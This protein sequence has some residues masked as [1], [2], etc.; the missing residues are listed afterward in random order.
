MAHERR[1]RPRCRRKKAEPAFRFYALWDKVYRRDVLQEAYRRCRANAGAAGV[2]RESSARI[3]TQGEE[4]WLERLRE[5]LTSGQYAPKP[6]LRM[7]IA[8]SNG[9]RRPLGIPCISD[10]VVGMAALLVIGPIFEADLLPQQ[11][12][13]RPGLDAKMALRRVYWHVTQH[14]RRE[15][16]DADLRDYFTSIPHSPLMRSLSRRIADGRLLHTIK[17]W[18]TAPA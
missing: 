12:G 9:G 6:L 18:L 14:G 13:F 8:K 15:V 3:E 11:Y 2:D 7:W 4:R 1:S 16:V 10:R 17:G 5:E